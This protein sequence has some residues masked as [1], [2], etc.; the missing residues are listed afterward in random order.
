MEW[1]K[2][3]AKIAAGCFALLAMPAGA[4]FVPRPYLSGETRGRVV[5]ADSGRPIEG[6]I[7]VARWE[8]LTYV[9]GN[10]H[11]GPSYEKVGE[12]VHVDEAV[13]DGGGGFTI[14]AWGP[15]LHTNGKM[16]E[17]VPRLLAFKPGYEP[18][19]Q[20]AGTQSP[21]AIRLKKFS[22]EPML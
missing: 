16:A 15:A 10:L 20:D 5:D 2:H 22:G 1:R 18:L 11:R 14:A 17:N 6:A 3:A 13:T 4:Q 21:I 12:A 19:Q 8:W 9:P 7:V